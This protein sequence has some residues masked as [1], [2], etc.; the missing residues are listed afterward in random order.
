MRGKVAAVFLIVAILVAAGAAGYLIGTVKQPATPYE[1]SLSTTTSANSLGT[2][3]S[4]STPGT[5]SITITGSTTL[6]PISWSYQGLSSAVMNSSEVNPHAY[7]YFITRYGAVSPGNGTQLFADLYVIGAQTLVGNWTTGYTM[8]YTGQ[9]IFNATVQYTEP[10]TY[11]VTGMLVTNL[12]NQSSQISFD[13]TQERAIGV[14]LANSTVK[15]DVGGLAYYVY[16]A[17]SQ[18]NGTFGYWVQIGQVNGYRNLAVLV[19]PDLTEV[20]EVVASTTYPNLGAP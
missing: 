1:N 19:N 5:T 17:D 6:V 4:E 10:S 13:A 7:Y 2:T 8:T 9:H 12:A 3:T 18:V 15:A 14:A 16:F 11:T 20:S